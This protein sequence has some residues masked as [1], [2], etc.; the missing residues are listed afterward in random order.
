LRRLLDET[1]HLARVGWGD[2]PP[3]VVLALVGEPRQT[4][5]EEPLGD[6]VDLGLRAEAARGDHGGSRALNEGEQ[7]LATAAHAGVLRTHREPPKLLS[8]G[9]R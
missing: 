4:F 1:K 8:L 5:G 2:L 3:A 6:A 7:R 9:W